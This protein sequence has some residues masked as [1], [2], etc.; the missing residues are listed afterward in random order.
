MCIYIYIYIMHDIVNKHTRVA[1]AFE[2]RSAR[3]DA[4]DGARASP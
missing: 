2:Q 4:G 1:I 3:D